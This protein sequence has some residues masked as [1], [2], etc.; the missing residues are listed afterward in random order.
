MADASHL[1]SLSRVDDVITPPAALRQAAYLHNLDETQ[2]QSIEHNEAFWA[3]V[4]GELEWFR[5]WDQVFEWERMF[6][7]CW[8]AILSGCMRRRATSK[9]TE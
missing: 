5:P 2:R 7:R 6:Q 1:E 3:N 8:S 9:P 4:A